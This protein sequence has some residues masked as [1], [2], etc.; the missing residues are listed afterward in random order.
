MTVTIIESISILRD[1]S[2]THR[3]FRVSQWFLFVSYSHRDKVECFGVNNVGSRHNK[4]IINAT[5]ESR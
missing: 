2:T 1:K 4:E 3:M 5:K